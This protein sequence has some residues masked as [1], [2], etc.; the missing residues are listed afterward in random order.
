MPNILLD[1]LFFALPEVIDKYISVNKKLDVDYMK[2]HCI[3]IVSI[4]TAKEIEAGILPVPISYS[5]GFDWTFLGYRKQYYLKY[6]SM[7]NMKRRIASII[8]F[9]YE[10]IRK[11]ECRYPFLIDENRP[12]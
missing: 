8:S 12:K 9:M 10:P 5:L 2:Q 1:L 11:L 4:Y 7:N 6:R 3:N